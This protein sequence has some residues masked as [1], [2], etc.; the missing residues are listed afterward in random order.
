[1]SETKKMSS[2][3]NDT[4]FRAATA[5]DIDVMISIIGDYMRASN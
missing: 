2:L 1:M 4:S 3:N 5:E